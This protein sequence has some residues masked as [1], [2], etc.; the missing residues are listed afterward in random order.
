MYLSAILC[1]YNPKMAVLE[2]ALASLRT[3]NLP[4]SGYEFLIIDNRS[5][6]ALPQSL[7][8]WHPRG[9]VV[10]EEES[11]LTNAR[12][13]GIRE[14]TGELIVFIDDDNVLQSDYLSLAAEIA[15]THPQLGA[16]GASIKAEFEVPPPRSILPYVEYLAC[17]E[18]TGDHWCNFDSK[19]STPSGAGLCVRRSVAERYV[20]TIA[21][22]PLRRAL[23]RSGKKLTS[24]EDH[25]LALTA[26]D[27]GLGVG[28]FHK[29]RLTHLIARQRLTE[30]Y[31]IRL[32]AGIGQCTKV[33]QAVRPHL[34]SRN[35]GKVEELRF[36]WQVVRGPMFERR[37]LLARRKA[38]R[39]AERVIASIQA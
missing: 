25:D 3:Q 26:T 29:L 30:D 37:L 31:I 36:W 24:G 10:R 8:A 4:V 2:R 1:T 13:R 6:N 27:M 17:S 35:A 23:G 12:L 5:E 39:E 15:S 16:F 9:R 14:S 11:G 22:D 34:K 19:W 32:Y 33:L 28:R 7:A 38:E 20:Q 18:I 21:G